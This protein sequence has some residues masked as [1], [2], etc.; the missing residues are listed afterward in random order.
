MKWQMLLLSLAT[1]VAFGVG[2]AK[3]RARFRAAGELESAERRGKW[4]LVVPRSPGIE[5]RSRADGVVDVP[6]PWRDVA[7]HDSIDVTPDLRRVAWID[8]TRYDKPQVIVASA[9]A[10][11]SPLVSHEGIPGSQLSCATFD[12][13]GGLLWYQT[14]PYATSSMGY[15]RPQTRLFGL[16]PGAKT[17][18]EITLP[19]A[20]APE[21][22]FER[23]ADGLV[24][25][26]AGTDG[27]IHTGRRDPAGGLALLK[28]FSGTDFALSRDGT[29]VV[30]NQSG[31]LAK[32]DVATGSI[33]NVGEARS[34]RIYAL[35]PDDEWVLGQGP[36]YN[37]SVA[38]RLS[39][40][41][42]VQMSV[43]VTNYGSIS[44]RQTWIA[45]T[46]EILPE[47]AATPKPRPTRTPRK[48]P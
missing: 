48:R 34:S 3:W 5:L 1:I 25:G 39:D 36:T 31:R 6:K 47:P 11:K 20:G 29:F 15:V 41:A 12:A 46:G 37:V 32:G 17:P 19:I 28:S 22:C 16:A 21:D 30:L 43:P 9:D 8:A 10:P 14:D 26:W 18:R 23:S 35:S 33:A 2:G 40:A 7:A 45:W 44:R 24:I 42:P 13:D 38:W 4:V 27:Q